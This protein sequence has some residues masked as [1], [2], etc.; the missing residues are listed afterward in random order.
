MPRNERQ[1]MR[2]AVAALV[3][4]ASGCSLR[5]QYAPA[6]GHDAGPTDAAVPPACAPLRSSPRSPS[7]PSGTEAHCARIVVPLPAEPWRVGPNTASDT[8]SFEAR[9]PRALHLDAHEVSARRYR[10]FVAA[11]AHTSEQTATYPDG[12][13]FA[14]T[15]GEPSLPDGH[16]SF[17]D[18]DD[19]LPMN[20]VSW[21]E[22]QAFCAWDGGRL[23]TIAELE[24]VRR[25][26]D[27][28]GVDAAG[29]DGRTFPWGDEPAASRFAE[30][31]DS[32]PA[33]REPT[34]PPP[35][36]DALEIGCF[37]GLAGGVTEWLADTFEPGMTVRYDDACFDDGLC[38][39]RPVDPR[40]VA[41]G[42]WTGSD[43][44]RLR[45]SEIVSRYPD[46]R[47]PWI[48]FRCAYDG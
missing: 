15:A 18:G 3:G 40:T 19:A 1:T 10:A 47:L 7:C 21:T 39:G 26:W 29:A 36:V 30:Y 24:F 13:G 23:P 31:P 4:I 20:C 35:R 37:F 25:W 17:D 9:G 34:P 27:R 5:I 22:A 16:C 8:G 48:G 6:E 11:A 43:E 38:E 44:E 45:S 32:F 2:A 28:A 41:T 12:A 46:D 14:V 42:S 33:S